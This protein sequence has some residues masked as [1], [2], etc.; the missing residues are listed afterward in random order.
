MS[1]KQLGEDDAAFLANLE[2]V[3][4]DG[5]VA[6]FVGAGV[7]HNSGLPLVLAIERHILEALG[8]EPAHAPRILEARLPFEAFIQALTQGGEIEPL[9]AMFEGGRPSTSHR[10]LAK[11]LQSGRLSSIFTT[12]FDTLI[13]D[14]LADEGWQPGRDYDLLCTTAGFDQARLAGA[15]PSVA[16]IHGSVTEK[17]E[18]AITLRQV[19]Q[20]S[21][22][23]SRA[24][25]VE[26]LFSRHWSGV[27]VLG[28]S[29]SDFFDLV[30]CIESV[31]EPSQGVLFVEHT[32]R[33]S[34]LC[35]T[36]API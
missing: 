22:V 12:N 24:R 28:Y 4:R 36:S 34:E 27:L 16:K 14:A 31:A 33:D 25:L 30:P 8:V 26:R 13:E 29:C 17:Q 9:F 1:H 2:R 20:R 23:A 7:S 21:L 11:L 35:G 6:A 15:R 18:M 32:S 5:P 10:F 19:S 3:L